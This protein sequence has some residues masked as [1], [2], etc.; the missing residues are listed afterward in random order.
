MKI[1]IVS[2]LHLDFGKNYQYILDNP[3]KP[4]A[5]TLILAGDILSE[6]GAKHQGKKFYEYSHPT[7]ASQ[8]R[9]EDRLGWNSLDFFDYVEANWQNVIII[10]GNHEFYGG[11]LGKPLTL[12]DRYGN[13]D[14]INRVYSINGVNFLCT[15]LWSPIPKNK[16]FLI[17]NM[18]NDYRQIRNPKGDLIGIEEI[19]SLHDEN[20]EWLN[21]WLQKLKGQKNVVV[22]HHLP[23]AKVISDK[24]K[25]SNINEAFY[26]PLDEMTK[27]FDIPVWIS[28]H[29]HEFSDKVINNTRFVR[30]PLGY[31]GIEESGFK[32]EFVIEV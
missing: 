25:G 22:T 32:P 21:T 1:Q 3:I 5:D 15:T 30:N 18:L 14:M 4:L 29:S 24:F 6:Y 20:V 17:R 27:E 9:P 10:P 12:S 2:D 26:A 28:G 31:V 16:D 7:D 11:V 8:N 23:T 13:V 19:N